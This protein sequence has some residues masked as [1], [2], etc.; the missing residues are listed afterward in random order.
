MGF[1]DIRLWSFLHELP[2]GQPDIEARVWR[3]LLS[4]TCHPPAWLCAS[5][6]FPWA[7]PSV[8][9]CLFHP[10]PSCLPVSPSSVTLSCLL[11]SLS[12]LNMFFSSPSSTTPSAP[13]F[14]PA[15]S[16]S[17]NHS[18]P[19]IIFLYELLTNL[20]PISASPS[21]APVL[22]TWVGGAHCL[23]EFQCHLFMKSCVSLCAHVP[24]LLESSFFYFFYF[25][26][27]FAGLQT[28][29]VWANKT[30]HVLLVCTN[31]VHL[32]R[33]V[34]VSSCSPSCW[35]SSDNKAVGELE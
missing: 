13:Y 35:K 28:K 10:L 25:L 21:S 7:R 34:W 15:L 30:P 26:F 31:S 6:I 24:Q 4:P 23:N 9:S 16:F 14:S 27:F 2:R 22:F 32:H 33:W 3:P 5:A 1:Q 8:L 18:S 29:Q 11:L 12:I 19:R 17:P 20:V